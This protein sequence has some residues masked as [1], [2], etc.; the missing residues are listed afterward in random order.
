MDLR[1]ARTFVAVAELGSISRAAQS[2]RIAQPALSRQ[3]QNLEQEFALRLFDRVKGG[4]RLTGQGEQL[5]GDCRALLDQANAVRDRAQFLRREESGVLKV[6]A[7]PSYIESLFAYFLHRYAERFPKVQVKLI[8]EHGPAM[9]RML[10]R[11]EINLGVI[12]A[13]QPD[14]G[15]FASH[16]LGSIDILAAFPPSMTPNKGRTIEMQH[17]TTY[18]LLLLTPDFLQRRT[19]DA[20]C[21]IAGLKSNILFESRDPRT[22]LAMAEAGH[23]IAIIPSVTRTHRYDL[24]IVAV[25]YRGKRLQERAFILWDKRRP[26]PR[27]AVDFSEMIAAYAHEISPITQPSKPGASAK[28]AKR[29]RIRSM[30]TT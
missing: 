28:G 26:R 19:F 12:H 13:L 10:E 9:L 29:R 17:L 18:P 6:A 24:R 5:L 20:A 11:G 14:D 30:G 7:A 1:Q 23:G 21:R 4:L 8:D 2:L 25:T 27:Y 16:L 3:I 22:L 15:R